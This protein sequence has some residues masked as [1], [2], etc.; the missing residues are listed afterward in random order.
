MKGLAGLGVQIAVYP[1]HAIEGGGHV[2]PAETEEPVGVPLRPAVI[3]GLPPV[4]DGA[5]ELTDRKR[6]RRV[7]QR[8]LGVSEPLRVALA[9]S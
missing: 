1:D 3:R 5:A 7:H 8:G 4:G 9:C 6:P 2:Q